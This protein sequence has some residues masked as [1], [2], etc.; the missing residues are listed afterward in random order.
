MS[1]APFQIHRARAMGSTELAREA[2]GVMPAALSRCACFSPKS[3]VIQACCAS[4]RMGVGL[5]LED[6]SPQIDIARIDA[7][8]LNSPL[9]GHKPRC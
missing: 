3:E 1:S 2:E 8:G 5:R 7:R 4:A 6:F 9:D